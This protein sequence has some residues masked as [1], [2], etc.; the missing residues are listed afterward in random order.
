[1]CKEEQRN[2]IKITNLLFYSKKETTLIQECN[3]YYLVEIMAYLYKYK[4]IYDD[5]VLINI[6]ALITKCGYV[7]KRG[8]GKTIEKFKE[9]LEFLRQKGYIISDVNFVEDKYSYVYVKVN[10]NVDG[11]F[12]QIYQDQIDKIK[13]YTGKVDKAKL[14]FLFGY[15]ASR[16]YSVKD[17]ENIDHN[18]LEKSANDEVG[19]NVFWDSLKNISSHIGLSE[20]TIINYVK[21]LKELELVQTINLDATKENDIVKNGVTIYTTLQGELGKQHLKA[22]KTQLQHERGGK[23]VVIN[24]NNNSLGGK[25]GRTKQLLKEGKRTVEEYN[26]LVKE[27]YP[28]DIIEFEKTIDNL[29]SRI[30]EEIDLLEMDEYIKSTGKY[31]NKYMKDIDTYKDY[32]GYLNQFAKSNVISLEEANKQY[33]KDKEDTTNIKQKQQDYLANV[34]L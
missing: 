4:S 25:V 31:I 14:L 24:N 10:L 16:E 19:T 33:D 17:A 26:E 30:D 23:T 11:Y 12:T 2:F 3:N 6:D 15:I 28:N 20:T 1:M 22:R 32:I 21:I 8:A 9:A 34:G 13:S 18:L 7:P 27:L 29:Y 5:E